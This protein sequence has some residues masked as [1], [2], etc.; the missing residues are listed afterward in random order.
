MKKLEIPRRFRSLGRSATSFPTTSTKEFRV[1]TIIRRKLANS[2]RRIQRRLDKT[3]LRG[4]SQPMFTARNIHYEIADR[5]RGIAV[6]GIGAIHALA[7]QLGLIDAID[8]RLHLLED[9]PPLPRVGPRP[10]PRLQRPCAAA[11]AC[12]TWNC[13]ATTKS[14]STPWA[15]AASPTPPPRATSAAAFTRT[16]FRRCRTSSTTPACG[17]GPSS[18]P[19]SST[20]PSSTWTASWSRPPASA[21]RAWTS[22][23]TA[24][25]ATTPWC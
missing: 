20:K 8:R 15:P 18:P 21:S 13:S 9:P 19:P 3:D 4:C 5:S 23:T 11:P 10:H 12:K 7:R 2:K 6:G 24:P 22:P 17:S 25:G 14:S 1:N 16:P